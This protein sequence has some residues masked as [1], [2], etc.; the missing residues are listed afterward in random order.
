[1]RPTRA[2][3]ATNPA[4]DVYDGIGMTQENAHVLDP[5]NAATKVFEQMETLGE[6]H[7]E[8]D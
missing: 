6:N 8:E 4:S 3:P 1:M 7:E 2:L 5:I